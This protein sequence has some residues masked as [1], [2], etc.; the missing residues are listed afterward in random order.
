[1]IPAE[2]KEIY[3]EESKNFPKKRVVNFLLT[4][5]ILF[6]TSMCVGSKYQ[7]KRL[8]SIEV[9]IVAVILF[10]IYTIVSTV[11]NAK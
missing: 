10:I 1:L 3:I 9:A 5:L 7:K 4:F 8:V 6:I 11:Y 2:L